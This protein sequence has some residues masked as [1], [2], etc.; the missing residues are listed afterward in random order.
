[1]L[2]LFLIP[3]EVA[4]QEKEIIHRGE[5]WLQYNLNTILAEKWA[6]FGNAGARW[7]DGFEKYTIFFGRFGARYSLNPTVRVATGFTYVEFNSEGSTYQVE[8]RPYEELL[9]VP[10]KGKKVGFSHRFRFEQRFYNPVVDHKVQSGNT[11]AVRFRYALS[12]RIPI[13]N[14]SESNPDFKFILGI[15]DEVMVNAGKEIVYNVFDKNRFVITP[16]LQFSKWMSVA[17]AYNYQFFNTSSAGEYIQ[18]NALWLHLSH[19]LNFSKRK[20][21]DIEEEH[22]VP[23]TPTVD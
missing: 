10:K 20:M 8:F 18:S 5:Q 4:S 1:M 14:L 13:A 19:T 7:R 6:M 21:E 12:T 23:V 16:T 3:T 17:L 9:V 11:F 15:S 22:H 2:V